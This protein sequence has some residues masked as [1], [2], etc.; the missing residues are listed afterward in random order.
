MSAEKTLSKGRRVSPFL[1]LAA[2]VAI[3]ALIL[4]AALPLQRPP[5]TPFQVAVNGSADWSVREAEMKSHH[6]MINLFQKQ[7]PNIISKYGAIMQIFSDNILASYGAPAQPQPVPPRNPSECYDAY[8]ISVGVNQ[9]IGVISTVDMPLNVYL[10]RYDQFASWILQR[11]SISSVW[12]G[13]LTPGEPLT[14]RVEPGHYVLIAY[15]SPCGVRSITGYLGYVAPT[16]VSSLDPVNTTGLLGFFN[17][18]SIEAYLSTPTA[19]ETW[20]WADLQ[21]NAVLEVVRSGRSRP[22]YFWVQNVI[23]FDTKAKR[24]RFVL[25]IWDV[26]S[27]YGI[28]V[29]QGTGEYYRG[30]GEAAYLYTTDAYESRYWRG[31]TL[32]LSGALFLKVNRSKDGFDLLFSYLLIQN[33]TYVAEESIYHRVHFEYGDVVDAHFASSPRRFL[34]WR[35]LW[36]YTFDYPLE[37]ELVFGGA[38]AGDPTTFRSMDAELAL[39]YESQG[40]WRPY[41]KVY[42]TGMW[43]AEAALNLDADISPGGL[44]RVF[45]SPQPSFKKLTDLFSPLVPGVTAPA[46]IVRVENPV[47][48]TAGAFFSTSERPFS[49]PEVLPCGE[50][51]RF[52]LTEV[53]VDRGF[54]VERVKSSVITVP[55][56]TGLRIT[57]L[58]PVYVKEYLVKLNPPYLEVNGSAAGELWVSRGSV[59]SV[60]IPEKVDL[61]NSTRLVFVSPGTRVLQVTSP[62]SVSAEFRRYYKVTISSAYPVQIKVTESGT[63]RTVQAEKFE[64]WLPENATVDVAEASAFNG[65][66][67]RSK[68]ESHRVSQPLSIDVQWSVDYLSTLAVVAALSAAAYAAVNYVLRRKRKA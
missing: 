40:S 5:P 66:F 46:A 51:C 9:G 16:G 47:N 41:S 67:L 20:S 19:G 43:T 4:G 49:F 42:S 11:E 24:L 58:T 38:A 33:G 8:D 55:P 62:T 48:G 18:S 22:D 14:L 32:P 17:I 52:R 26:S 34:T 63:P 2:V 30:L 3:A 12:S 28:S 39:F 25:N 57:K 21:L 29:V 23:Q 68:P 44:V 61:P 54:S 36:V 64:E 50:G 65:V 13:V 56:Y 27:E 45:P 6:E 31:Y 10:V 37:V 15:P 59:I 60:R 35:L 1:A 53:V 7:N